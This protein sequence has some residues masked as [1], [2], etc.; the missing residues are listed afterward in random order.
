MITTCVK[1][2]DGTSNLMLAGIQRVRLLNAACKTPFQ[3]HV[4]ELADSI[5]DVEEPVESV[6]QELIGICKTRIP[7]TEKPILEMLKALKN[8][9][10]LTDQMCALFIEP[11]D[12][13]HKLMQTLSLK[14]RI[15]TL[16]ILL[17]PKDRYFAI[18]ILLPFA[19]P[20]LQ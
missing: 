5:H 2:K 12:A 8:L 16:R 4:I 3:A 19:L 17:Q 15:H 1:Q 11:A 10:Q 7:K 18:P 20:I 9:D 13:R 14:N 6:I